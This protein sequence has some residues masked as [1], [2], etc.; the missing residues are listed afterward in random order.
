MVNYVSENEA[1]YDGWYNIVEVVN[2]F[3]AYVTMGLGVLAWLVYSAF[4]PIL[5]VLNLWILIFPVVGGVLY[6]LMVQKP[7]ADKDLS[8]KTHIWLLISMV[9]SVIGYFWA[10]GLILLIFIMAGILSEKPIWVALGE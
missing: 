3:A 6:L 4:L 5:L 9:V 2:K 1:I 8:K 7:M 10:G